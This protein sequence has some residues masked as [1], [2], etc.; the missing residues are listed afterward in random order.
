[1]DERMFMSVLRMRRYWLAVTVL[2]GV[3][4]IGTT[5]DAGAQQR[6]KNRGDSMRVD[7]TLAFARNGT[8]TV[9]ATSGDI[10][11]TGWSRDQVHVQGES[12]GGD[13]RVESSGS[14]S[15]MTV[16]VGAGRN[17]GGDSRFEISVPFGARVIARSHSGDVSVHGTRGQVE[18]STQSGD[19]D[20]DDVTTRLSVNTFS[21]AVTAGSITGDAV[22]ESISGDVRV[23][24]LRGDVDVSTVS[25]GIEMRGMTSKVVRA[26]T[27][28]GDV[29]YDGLIDAA[30]KY[31]MTAHS[32]D[33][34]LHVQRDASAQISV[35]TWSGE[36]D[37]DFPMTLKP[38]EHGI[39]SQKAKRFTFSIGGGAARITADTFNGD[40]KIS[41]NGR[42]ANIRR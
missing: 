30:G 38:G 39:G 15:R 11:V 16:D 19:I 2:A 36:I 1:M 34:R 25:G 10:V 7:T 40:I 22:I 24:D 28:S 18:A 42:G 27:T 3:L 4:C 17:R 12:E 20:V 37:S 29:T 9:T 23:S 41:S 13:I 32:G 14:G 26:K 5:R 35:S 8:V 21:G 6:R 31:D 33:I